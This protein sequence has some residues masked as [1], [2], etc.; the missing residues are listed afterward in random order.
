[1]VPQS[2]GNRH[3]RCRCLSQRLS[4]A[5]TLWIEIRLLP[6]THSPDT[7]SIALALDVVGRGV[8]DRPIVPD[9]YIV[10]VLPLEADLQI[11]VV[12]EQAVEPVEQGFGLF[13]R[14]IV[15]VADVAADRE[16]GLPARGRVG[17]YDGV[18]GCRWLVSL[19]LCNLF[20]GIVD[21]GYRGWWMVPVNSRPTFSGAPRGLSYI[22][23]PPFSAA[24]M[25]PGCAKVAVR[26]SRNFW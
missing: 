1:M 9:G 22:V 21:I 2:S 8:E 6:D 5:L 15:D 16:D 4:P 12:D 23:K 17:A 18:D 25:K 14:D 26:P 13:V 24:S 3:S 20:W 10:A 11:V 7:I 19:A